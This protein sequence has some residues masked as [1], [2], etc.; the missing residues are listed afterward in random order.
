MH[1]HRA[2]L[3]QSIVAVLLCGA[4]SNGFAL[5]QAQTAAHPAATTIS[6][7]IVDQSGGL[8]IANASLQL[9]QAG[10]TVSTTVSNAYGAFTFS[11]VPQGIY[12][13]VVRAAGYQSG[14]SQDIVLTGPANVN[15][16]LVRT[17]AANQLKTIANVRV[18][19]AGTL[20]TTTTIQNNVDV[21][22]VQQ[23]N[24]TRIAERLG[25][26]AGRESRRCGLLP[27]R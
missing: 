5:A 3:F 4:L 9:Q 7:V 23:T 14:R 11:A 12:Q 8:A 19:G 25:K 10:K 20:Q 17:T 27:R 18:G 21:N 16:A 6:G 15:I 1:L 2:K 24:Q 26:A 13:I 22:V